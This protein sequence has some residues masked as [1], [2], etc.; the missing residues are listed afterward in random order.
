M[1]ASAS[2]RADAYPDPGEDEETAKK[3]FPALADEV[4]K[5]EELMSGVNGLKAYLEECGDDDP[6][7]WVEHRASI[8]SGVN[9]HYRTK[10]VAA[11]GLD[12]AEGEPLST[13]PLSAPAL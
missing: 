8:M 6:D 12:S 4:A 7:S 1:G 9:L 10:A 3:Q 2:A 13:S 11:A 5:D